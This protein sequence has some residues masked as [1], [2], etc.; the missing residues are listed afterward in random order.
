MVK[1]NPNQYQKYINERNMPIKDLLNRLDINPK[2][3]CDLGSGPGNSTNLLKQKFKDAKVI[4]VDSSKDMIEKAK[5]NYGNLEFILADAKNI[6]NLGKFDLIFSN[7][8]IH[9]IYGQTDLIESMFNALNDNGVLAIQIPLTQ[10]SDFYKILYE[11]IEQPKWQKLKDINNFHNLMP[12]GYYEILLNKT[13]DFTIWESTYYHSVG[14][15]EGVIEW[16]KGSGLK[17]YL[18]RLD[19][20]LKEEFENDLITEI[21]KK[22]K[23]YKDGSVILKMPRMFFIAKKGN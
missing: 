1:W 14:S 5:E 21:K 19:D 9:W 15:Y 10:K 18:D 3:I 22:Y 4:G 12:E 2:I 11:L 20:L 7:A 13:Q 6:E 8:C 17:P 23:V 16:Y